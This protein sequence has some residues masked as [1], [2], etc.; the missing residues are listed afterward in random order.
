MFG[1]TIDTVEEL[2]DLLGAPTELSL[3]KQ[4][5]ELDGHMRAFIAASPFLVIG[6]F[7][8]DGSCDVSPRGDPQ[9][10]VHVLDARHLVIPERPG[11]RRADSLRNIL[12][13]GRAALLF[14]V[15]GRGDTLRVNGR[16]CIT[17]EESLLAPCAV[18][19]KR[20]S[21]GIGLEVEECFLQCAKA[22]IRSRLWEAP[23]P[24]DSSPLPC[25]A[26]M[27][28]DQTQVAGHTVASLQALIDEAYA[29]KL[30]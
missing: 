4:L 26:E 12:E 18:Q 6:T 28:M 15:P 8:R 29:T 20:P 11:N 13:T 23:V 1:Q 30:Y 19:G 22:L 10:L 21:L 25:L 14:L 27:L 5:T 3:K 2:R 9:G 16:A 24:Q 17:G 7:A